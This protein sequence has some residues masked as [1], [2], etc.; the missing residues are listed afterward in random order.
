MSDFAPAHETHGHAAPKASAG[1][2]GWILVASFLC[3]GG[4][5]L[6]SYWLAS[7]AWWSFIG[8]PM[9][10]GGAYLFFR[11]VTGPESA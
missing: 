4:L 6:I 3:G 8:A 11:T 2:I 9:V 1:T 5:F 10:G 7:F